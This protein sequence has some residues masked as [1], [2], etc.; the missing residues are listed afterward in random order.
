M[1]EDGVNAN[2]QGAVKSLRLRINRFLAS[3]WHELTITFVAFAQH[4]ALDSRRTY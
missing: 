3:G 1:A 4:V 2:G